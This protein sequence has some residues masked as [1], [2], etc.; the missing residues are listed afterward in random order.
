MSIKVII[1]LINNAYS[2]WL[3]SALNKLNPNIT[4]VSI[5]YE[6]EIPMSEDIIKEFM[7]NRTSV[8]ITDQETLNS[9]RLSVEN[10][11][12]IIHPF[13]IILI[14][15]KIQ[16]HD[17]V[18]SFFYNIIILK[19]PKYGA[20]NIGAYFSDV[21]IKLHDKLKRYSHN[22]DFSNNKLILDS[23][24][25]DSDEL[26]EIIACLFY[27]KHKITV[28]LLESISDLNSHKR[29]NSILL[30]VEQDNFEPVI[31]K[32]SSKERIKREN[33]RYTQFIKGRLKYHYHSHIEKC[34]C[35]WNAG[36][37]IYS[38]AW[39]GNIMPIT[40]A[41]YYAQSSPE[42]ITVIIRSIFNNVLN[43][44]YKEKIILQNS[45]NIKQL[46]FREK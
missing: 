44:V 22:I 35:L 33:Q 29:T 1:L 16:T 18:N 5:A 32:I 39:T 19:K 36:G 45:K 13:Q 6:D 9:M 28:R 10:L 15:K 4:S 46:N 11:T 20:T 2:R 21:I 23:I 17:Y 8:L 42:N 25:I 14:T 31:L 30:F 41:D 7:R 26:N 12:N 3:A 27:D 24:D 40:F 34:V 43:R 38:L 37:L